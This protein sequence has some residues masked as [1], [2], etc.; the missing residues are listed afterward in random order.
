MSRIA[1]LPK[2]LQKRAEEIY[3]GD[4]I[5]EAQA[6]AEALN[7][8]YKYIQEKLAEI[9]PTSPNRSGT[10]NVYWGQPESK[11]STRILSN[12]APRKFNYESTDGV[13]RE[14]GSVEHAYQTNKNGKFNQATYDAYVAKGGFGIKISPKLTQVG[15]R[16]NL[17]LMEDLVVESFVQNPNS[18]AAKKLLQYENFT[19][20]TNTLI[21]QAFLK[22]LKLA[23]SELSGTISQ[24]TSLQDLVTLPEQVT[25]DQGL[26]F[27][28]T[29]EIEQAVYDLALTENNGL[30]ISEILSEFLTAYVDIA[31]DP[32]ILEI[33][34]V[35]DLANPILMM[36]R[37][38]IPLKSIFYFMNQDVIKRYIKNKQIYGSVSYMGSKKPNKEEIVEE[39]LDAYKDGHGI[40][41]SSFIYKAEEDIEEA[42]K[43]G[44]EP[45]RMHKGRIY[46]EFTENELEDGLRDGDKASFTHHLKVLDIFLETERQSRKF[47]EMLRSSDPDT[48]G[49]KTFTMLE[50]QVKL[51]DKVSKE[52]NFIN[53]D[54]LFDGFIGT[55]YDVKEDYMEK[56]KDFFISQSP[57]YKNILDQIKQVIIDSIYDAETQERMFRTLENDFVIYL[58]QKT[59]NLHQ[60]KLLDKHYKGEESIVRKLVK[61]QKLEKGENSWLNNV[62]ASIYPEGDPTLDSLRPLQK[63]FKT[64]DEEAM[65]EDYNK[66]LNPNKR[67]YYNDALGMKEGDDF[68]EILRE[69]LVS[70]SGANYSPFNL[71]RFLPDSEYRSIIK[72]TLLEAENGIDTVDFIGGIDENRKIGSYMLNNMR[73]F[74]KSTY[75]LKFKIR[76]DSFAEKYYVQYYEG[77]IPTEIFERG[78]RNFKDYRNTTL[79]QKRIPP[80]SQM[81]NSVFLNLKNSEVQE[82]NPQLEKELTAYL[83]DLGVDVK[84]VNSIVDENGNEINAWGQADLIEQVINLANGEISGETLSEE[85][86]HMITGMLGMDHPII[87]QMMAQITGYDVYDQVKAEYA[88]VY[89]TEEQFRFEAVGKLIGRHIFKKG[90]LPQDQ[91]SETTSWWNRALRVLK[92]F[93]SGK[94]FKN[95]KREKDIFEQ[96]ADD[97]LA[98]KYTKSDMQTVDEYG[99]QSTVG[100]TYQERSLAKIGESYNMKTNGFMSKFVNPDEIQVVLNKAGF[101]DIKVVPTSN[102]Q[103][104]F[105]SRNGS[106]INPFSSKLYNLKTQGEVF[107]KIKEVSATMKGEGMEKFIDKDGT[108]WYIDKETGQAVADRVTARVSRE[109]FEKNRS[110][111]ELERI[112]KQPKSILS[113]KYGVLGH[114]YYDQFMNFTINEGR[115][116]YSNIRGDEKTAKYTVEPDLGIPYVFRKEMSDGTY[117]LLNHISNRQK[118]IDEAGQPP[119]Q[120]II[121][122]EQSIR[123]DIKGVDTA[124]TIDVLVI[125]SDG[126]VSLYDYKFMSL[127][128][129]MIGG[130]RVIEPIH[131]AK[132]RSF[133][134]QIGMYKRM[135]TGHG[136]ERF[137]DTRILPNRLHFTWKTDPNGNIVTDE[138]T[139][140]ESFTKGTGENTDADKRVR[141]LMPLPVQRELT[142]DKT[143]DAIL[144]KLFKQLDS[145]TALAKKNYK[146]PEKMT[147]INIQRGSLANVVQEIQVNSD[148]SG[149]VETMQ[150][151]L[152]NE[153][154]IIDKAETV[155]D[156]HELQILHE[157]I[158]AYMEV[159]NFITGSIEET[160]PELGDKA[161]AVFGK[162]TSAQTN[163]ESKIKDLFAAE[164]PD[165]VKPQKKLGFWSSWTSH[166]S[167]IAQPAF[168]IARKYVKKAWGDINRDVEKVVEEAK[169][170]RN[171]LLDWAKSVGISLQDAYRKIINP[172]NGNLIYTFSDDFYSQRKEAFEEGNVKWLKAQYKQTEEGRKKYDENLKEQERRYKIRGLKG[173]AFTKAVENWK[174]NN[175]LNLQSAWT[176][177]YALWNYAEIKDPSKWYS[178]EYKNLLR[179]ENKA[180]KRYFDWY[181]KKNKEFNRL[182]NVPER[183]GKSFV[184]NI[185]KD[186]MDRW[187]QDG[188]FNMMTK[189]SVRE[190]ADSMRIRQND[191]MGMEG[192]DVVPLLYHDNFMYKDKN[193]DWVSDVGRKTEDLTS[194]MILFAGSVYRKHH[195]S[196]ITGIM[197]ALKLH[198]SEQH[199]IKTDFLGN[200]LRN[201]DGTYQTEASETNLKTFNEIIKGTVYGQK[202]Q[203]GDV[204]IPINGKEY[205]AT[206][207]VRHVM[208]WLS[209]KALGFNYVSAFGNLAG[210]HANIFIK[211]SGGRFFTKKQ[212]SKTWNMMINRG[213]ENTFHHAAEYFNVE[214]ER[215]IQRDAAK[216]SAS[217]ITR[218]LT[219]DKI[220]LLQQKGDE[221][222]G[223]IVLVS[224]MQNYGIDEN[225]KIKR[226]AQLPEGTKSILE[227]FKKD[228]DKISVEGLDND[229]FDDFRGRVMYEAR[230]IKGT[231]TQEDI[232]RMQTTIA[233]QVLLQ[234]RSWLAPMVS[235][236][237]DSLK[238]TKEIE[239]WEVGRYNSLLQ[240]LAR[241][242][243]IPNMMRI[244]ADITTLGVWKYK[245]GGRKLLKSQ[246]ETFKKNNPDSKISIDEYIE[247][248][249]R[250]VREAMVEA[251]MIAGVLTML[252]FAKADWDDD[253]VANYRE[254]FA[255]RQV[256]KLMNRAYL[257]LSFFSNPVSFNA[258]IKDPIPILSVGSDILGLGAN[259]ITET[260]DTIASPFGYE[261]TDDKTGKFHYTGKMLVGVRFLEQ[262]WDD[263]AETALND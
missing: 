59:Q 7:E 96:M 164:N 92:R 169:V 19:H 115:E 105:F 250:T 42:L 234:F 185:K 98:K 20:N 49:F 146:N 216:L 36:V 3:M 66:L 207:I 253:G 220:Y 41:A 159:Q 166:L 17:Q 91:R 83:K 139:R 186:A 75:N 170:E 141:S 140:V 249:E 150:H 235:E 103:G 52:G 132:K 176:N 260:F 102:G 84:Y 80:P 206:K 145:L 246:F 138:M 232:S 224:M 255:T 112:R 56:L 168:E 248:R 161:Y 191:V 259:T 48:R 106:K 135:L 179:P 256:Y 58:A 190:I 30:N 99:P 175:D 97:I 33:N 46:N 16:G 73:D 263:Y 192:E 6:I 5:T 88:N 1:C 210:G 53:F 215:W 119:G 201:E 74:F 137:D 204:S 23:Q 262:I 231:N 171:L 189:D 104:Y 180:L 85:A 240:T 50:N 116:E 54:S 69:F 45:G 213:K 31:K 24:E 149:L 127:K 77:G 71:V 26:Q 10:I 193:G 153:Q 165:I 199:V 32:Y 64:V 188:F 177:K 9:A 51:R 21:D 44:K 68:F 111:K 245:A 237:Y 2:N 172:D 254:T 258:L 202:M 40:K 72:S 194:A 78:A 143:I 241:E 233:G 142:G 203:G 156:V 113:K 152:E 251:R 60:N 219:Y 28:T 55:F 244:I 163:I 94:T 134:S 27:D 229:A 242:K 148:L 128:E 221:M 178:N 79:H 230:Q 129:E 38:G 15:K 13:T 125:Y 158:K 108:P 200:P 243:F 261:N 126:T 8:E 12:L 121:L 122:T 198:L 151:I 118:S 57:Q 11:K 22:G 124:G 236:R 205:S 61:L 212:L 101:T 174:R 217:A 35:T 181:V 211:A 162:L 89:T 136:V 39:T 82:V 247:L 227:R 120:A 18:E 133:E 100:L 65:L 183:I 81:G 70:Q 160:N 67:G 182:A 155:D 86:A 214:K 95:V 257:E 226:L 37:Q 252:M 29:E 147:E 196:N 173:Y 209:A 239:E 47:Q 25:P 63:K 107:N 225:G 184:A 238:Y 114:D 208:S 144:V 109:G 228:G 110:I 4:D 62:V 117:R 218:N 187:A 130:K 34:A 43:A 167:K 87:R 157:Q 14:Y 223:N 90:S 123:G 222:V 93:L 76:F 197:D 131:W 195:M 154:D